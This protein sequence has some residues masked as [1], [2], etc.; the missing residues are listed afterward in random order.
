MTHRIVLDVPLLVAEKAFLNAA[1]F[2][3][4]DGGQVLGGGGAVAYG[5][6]CYPRPPYLFQGGKVRGRSEKRDEAFPPRLFAFGWFR[7]WAS[8]ARRGF[9]CGTLRGC[10]GCG[11]VVFL[12]RIF[13][14]AYPLKAGISRL[15]GAA[16]VA[17]GGGAAAG[18]VGG[19]SHLDGWDGTGCSEVKRFRVSDAP[20]SCA[21]KQQVF[22]IR[23]TVRG[24][25]GRNR[26]L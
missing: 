1:G 24:T 2:L 11:H 22:L 4:R 3:F 9:L 13:Q 19:A 23:K 14:T 18:G 7:L 21:C 17:S 25:N 15:G 20:E 5:R 26:N 10:F 16:G 6:F 12:S 8:V